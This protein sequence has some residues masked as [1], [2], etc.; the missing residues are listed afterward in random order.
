MRIRTTLLER[1]WLGALLL[2]SLVPS[3]CDRDR[4]GAGP[5]SD[6]PDGVIVWADDEDRIPGVGRM[7][8]YYH[9]G[10]FVVWTDLDRGGGGSSSAN[11]RGVRCE[12]FLSGSEG[13]RIEFRCE[14]PDGRTGSATIEGRTYDLSEGGV[15]LVAARGD[16]V[17]VR[18]LDRELETVGLGG[19]R[20]R[21]IAEQTPE[22]RAFFSEDRDEDP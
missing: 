1:S 18:Q 9:G 21:E 16:A 13:R 19:P 3:G 15:F 12:G 7:S 11:A 17:R 10:L 8:V 20:L 4:Q 5:W 2:S 6:Q 14:S 22:I